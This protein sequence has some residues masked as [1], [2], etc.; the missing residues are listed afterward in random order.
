MIQKIVALV[1]LCLLPALSQADCGRVLVQRQAFVHRNVV[2][3]EAAFV[4]VPVTVPL[5]STGYYPQQMLP[6]GPIFNDQQAKAKS[7][8]DKLWAAIERLTAVVDQLVKANLPQGP[9]AAEPVPKGPVV[10]QD[11]KL[12]FLADKARCG[13]CHGSVNP[14]GKLDLTGGLGKLTDKQLGLLTILTLDHNVDGAMPPKDSKVEP[15]RDEEF[16][17][18][19]GAVL[20]ELRK[21]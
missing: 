19:H 4:A 16:A 21:R 5:F 14:K 6:P 13:K 10:A 15:L 12:G 7:E 20:V 18:L 11:D 17:A 8:T 3:V 2:A 1:A 9:I